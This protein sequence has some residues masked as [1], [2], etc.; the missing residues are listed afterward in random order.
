MLPHLGAGAGQGIED[1]EMLARLL[2]HPETKADNVAVRDTPQFPHI[3]LTF[4][5]QEVLKAYDEVCRPRAQSVWDGSL[6]AG[7]TYDCHG[8]SGSSPG[9]L[10]KDL[11]G[12]RDF[13]WD[14]DLGADEKRAIESLRH[15]DVFEASGE[16]SN[17][18]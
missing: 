13:I 7:T 12:I 1:A 8:K 6:T 2:S 10:R 15:R 16:P 17:T 14:Y 9:G 11:A 5:S 3:E 18:S 4:V